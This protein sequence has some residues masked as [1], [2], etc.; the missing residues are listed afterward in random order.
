M[1]E[2]LTR[3]PSINRPQQPYD[4]YGHQQAYAQEAYEY[5]GGAEY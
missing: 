2:A 1:Q 3:G 4:H 5:N